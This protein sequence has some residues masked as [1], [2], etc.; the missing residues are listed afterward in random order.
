MKKTQVTD[1]RMNIRK[2]RVSFLSIAVIAAMAVT[3]YLGLSFASRA[4]AANTNRFYDA[5]AFRDAEVVSTLLLSEAD[6]DALRSTEGIADAEPLWQSSGTLTF[7]GQERR[8]GLRSLTERIGVPVLV[9]GRLPETAEECVADWEIA[10]GTSLELGDTVIVEGADYL[11]TTRFTVCGIAKSG[12]FAANE[13]NTPGDRSLV[14]LPAAFDLDALE[15]CCMRAL[16]RYADSAGLDRFDADWFDRFAPVLQRVE[17]LAESRTGLRTEEVR[18]LYGEQLADGEQTLAEAEAELADARRQLDEGWAELTEGETAAADAKALLEDSKQQLDD[19]AAQLAEGEAQ[20]ADGRAELANA[21]ATLDGS[22]LRLSRGQAQLDEAAALLADGRAQLDAGWA[23]YRD[24]ESQLADAKAQLDEGAELLADGRRQLDEAAAELAAGLLALEDGEEQYE[25]AG[26]ELRAARAE[27]S[28]GAAELADAKAQL[29]AGA[30]ELE[31]GKATIRTALKDALDGALGQDSSSWINWAPDVSG[32]DADSADAR[33]TDF[34]ITAELTLDLDLSMAGNIANVL[35]LL[36]RKGVDEDALIAAVETVYGALELQPEESRIG[37]AARV[38]ADACA[39]VAETYETLA[40]G[41]RTWDAGHAEYLAGAAAL[42]QGRAAYADGL[43][44]YRAAR[45]ELDAGWEA[46][47]SGLERYTEGKAELEAK[48]A[49]YDAGLAQYQDGAARLAEGRETLDRSEAEYAEKLAEFEAGKAELE[50]GWA[51]YYAGL[52]Q[53]VAGQNTLTEKTA[54]FEAA[55]AQYEDGLAQYEAGLAEYEAALE[56]L[57][58]GRAELEDGEAQYAQG[59]EDYRAGERRLADAGE[60]L[61]TLE[62]CRWVVLD[63]RGNACYQV[64]SGAVRNVSD[65]GMTFALIFILVGA[66]VIYATLG[67]IVEE[68]RRLVGATR[69][70][71]FYRREVLAKYLIFGMGATLLGMLLGVALGYLMIQPILTGSYGKFYNFDNTALAFVPGKTL[72][73]LLGGLILSAA[74]VWSA[75]TELLRSTATSLMQEKAPSAK[76][77]ARNGKGK[78]SLYARLILLN[79]RTD[80]KRV[81]VTVVSVAGCCALLVAGFTMREGIVEAIDRQYGS[82]VRYDYRVEFS[83]EAAETAVPAAREA[84][85]RIG[86]ECVTVCTGNRLLSSEGRLT[87]RVLLCGELDEMERF[88]ARQ[89]LRT[90]APL[91]ADPEGVWIDYKLADLNGFQA[92]DTVTLYAADMKPC[93]ARVAGVYDCYVGKEL[94]MSRESYEAIF[95]E[96]PEDNGLLVLRGEAEEARLEELLSSLRGV[97]GLESTAVKRAE[98]MELAGVLNMIAALLVGIAGIMACFILLNLINMHV[99][100]KKR[101]L[102]IMRVNGFTVREVVAY[103]ARETVVTNLLGIVLGLGAGA[104]LGYRM[105][106]L[107]EGAQVHFVREPQLTALLLSAAITALFSIILNWIALRKVKDLKLTDVA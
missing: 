33:A 37:A 56:T 91:P 51:Q 50:N 74:A 83:R 89:D 38:I 42:E 59:L 8:V 36:T 31:N 103:I 9:S 45:A 95:G 21:K 16:L 107:L 86:A 84:L 101:E 105:I 44:Q 94:M 47:N 20:L 27:L 61:D 29:D 52:A 96:A 41:A 23:E 85:S 13:M 7:G 2:Q 30:A 100:Q 48:A 25:A 99:S 46:H 76:Q 71:G 87:A 22:Y 53:Y 93:A 67:R 39:S 11:L 10:K 66:L 70:L 92:G 88:Y 12:D 6:L 68:Q 80:K 14:V 1:A 97:E 75:C 17:T 65:M 79:I 81:A 69:A 18:T 24:G 32:L 73:V 104:L 26:A 54:E 62:P 98:T 78:L 5:A 63:L 64:I 49:E 34:P 43:A 19:G 60:A 77:R 106:C 40:S 102:T 90:A 3:A 4:I 82:I 35:T 15:G 58:A 72:I 28:A 55:K 57:S